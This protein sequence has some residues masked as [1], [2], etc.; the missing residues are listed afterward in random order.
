[1]KN[2]LSAHY[3]LVNDIDCSDTVNW[4]RIFLNVVHQKSISIH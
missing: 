4:S 1:M 3:E 2:D